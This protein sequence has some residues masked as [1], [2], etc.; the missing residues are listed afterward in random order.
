MR[1]QNLRAKRNDK[2]DDIEFYVS[3]AVGV[4]VVAVMLFFAIALISHHPHDSTPFH[5]E[6]DLYFIRNWGGV[7][8]AYLSVVLF[9][10]FGAGAYFFVGALGILAYML[11]LGYR[12]DRSW[13]SVLLLPACV[14]S[15]SLIASL[16]SVD[17]VH[18]LP[19]GQIG[20]ML[21]TYLCRYIGFYGAAV[22]AWSIL[23]VSSVVIVRRSIV[24]GIIALVR[25]VTTS[26]ATFFF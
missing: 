8:G 3:E 5:Y 6:S 25:H 21:S 20:Y 24:R 15:A 22:L 10:L 17:F 19:G 26:R 14:V 13:L 9:H 11:M 2:H 18:G 12:H 23:W 1:S 7:A 4:A 16:Y